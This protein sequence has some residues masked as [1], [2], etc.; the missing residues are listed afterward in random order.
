MNDL[1]NSIQGKKILVI[2]DQEFMR[3]M[4]V[5]IIKRLGCDAVLEAANGEEGISICQQ[6]MPD[7]VICDINM[8]PVDGI[9]FLRRVRQA[10]GGINA[11]LPVI[12][13]TN[14]A[15]EETVM[16]AREYR[17]NAFIVKPVTVNA[18]ENKLGQVLER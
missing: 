17:A 15:Q 18:I 8:K 11:T 6:S 3:D 14:D 5:R 4:V 13:L 1:K 2:E 10:E 9:E 16:A 12:F 7:A